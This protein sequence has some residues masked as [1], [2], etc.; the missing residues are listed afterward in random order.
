MHT[1]VWLRKSELKKLARRPVSE[2]IILKRILRK[3]GWDMN[4]LKSGFGFVVL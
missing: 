3:Y 4:W 1:K 2:R